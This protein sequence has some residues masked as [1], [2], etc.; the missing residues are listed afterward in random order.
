MKNLWT[1]NTLDT[2]FDKYSESQ[3]VDRLWHFYRSHLL[4]AERLTRIA[5]SQDRT[6]Y[7]D[8]LQ[9][10][11]YCKQLKEQGA[12]A[13]QLQPCFV[14]ES[15]VSLEGV[16]E[17]IKRAIPVGIIYNL[18]NKA[19]ELDLVVVLE[20]S[21][22]KAYEEFED[23]LDLAQLGFKKGRCTVHSYGLLHHLM[24][25]GHVFYNTACV[26]RN[27]IY[28][29]NNETLFNPLSQQLFKKIK[30]EAETQFKN[31]IDKASIFMKAHSYT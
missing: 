13:I 26:A 6:F 22:T 12:L 28:Q 20:K 3:Y 11:Q 17:L 31:G 27:V 29:K 7:N 4:Y 2:F 14:E 25:N 23:L 30:A 24:S 21:C 8:L 19:D 1:S 10:L 9:L 16:I 5:S 18:S 15:L